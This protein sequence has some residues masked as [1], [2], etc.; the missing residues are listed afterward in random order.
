MYEIGGVY[1]CTDEKE[2]KKIV[3]FCNENNCKLI[4]E[5]QDGNEDL[6]KIV[7]HPKPEQLD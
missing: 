1:N 7:E 6:L 4:K 2:L 3:K 5:R